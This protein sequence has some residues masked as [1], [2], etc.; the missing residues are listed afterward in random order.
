[1]LRNNIIVLLTLTILLASGCV[2]REKNIVNFDADYSDQEQIKL[3]GD[4]P[5]EELGSL[6]IAKIYEAVSEIP[7]ESPKDIPLY[8]SS[9]V[10][11]VG[12]FDALDAGSRSNTD[13]TEGEIT[14]ADV[15]FCSR[16]SEQEVLNHY[17]TTL[18]KN[19]NYQVDISDNEIW[20]TD[21]ETK[22][23]AQYTYYR[24]IHIQ[25]QKARDKI[26]TEIKDM[27]FRDSIY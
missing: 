23:A 9:D 26:L 10:V 24:V 7:P 20:A 3:C 6:F 25:V 13:I 18:S 4:W 21:T 17:A 14:K 1:M 5:D 22:T 16:G 8:S 12:P 27:E 2:S 15:F 19:S 11:A